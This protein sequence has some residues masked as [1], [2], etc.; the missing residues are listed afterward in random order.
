MRE[1]GGCE[2]STDFTIERRFRVWLY[3]VS[4]QTLALRSLARFPGDDTVDVWFEGVES[5]NLH[6]SFE[7][8]TVRTADA[9]ERARIFAW[10]AADIDDVDR[11]PPLCLILGSA[12]PDGFVV[13]AH[14]RVQAS[15]SGPTAAA[16][17]GNR[18]NRRPAILGHAV[19]RAVRTGRLL[20]RSGHP[21]AGVRRG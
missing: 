18:V 20:T 12:G 1:Q 2:R 13:C 10:A 14:V 15:R 5:M 7:P 19:S 17:V 16:E 21:R 8:L 3:T 9:G 4:H 6:K 11:R